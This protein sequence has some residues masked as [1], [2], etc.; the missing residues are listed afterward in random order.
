[1]DKYFSGRTGNL[2]NSMV[3]ARLEDIPGSHTLASN[4]RPAMPTFMPNPIGP[5]GRLEMLAAAA[6]EQ[7]PVRSSSTRK[8]C[9][10]SS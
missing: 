6:L 5:Q 7:A 4:C 9:S 2:A 3:R 1:M 8:C 10:G